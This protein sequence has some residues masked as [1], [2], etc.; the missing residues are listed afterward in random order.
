MWSENMREIHFFGQ[1]YTKSILDWIN[2]KRRVGCNFIVSKNP[3]PKLE[4]GFA[5]E[6]S[7]PQ[8]N[9]PSLLGKKLNQKQ[10]PQYNSGMLIL[11]W[12]P[13]W[14]NLSYELRFSTKSAMGDGHITFLPLKFGGKSK[15][16]PILL[17][18]FSIIADDHWLMMEAFYFY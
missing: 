8:S 9:S 15:I 14:S 2:T 11:F 5:R 13:A 18:G 16:K 10:G 12:A 7:V 1:K 3:T 6:P 4:K 17:S